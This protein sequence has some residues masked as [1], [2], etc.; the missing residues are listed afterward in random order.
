MAQSRETK[1]GEQ[2]SNLVE[3]HFFNPAQV[4]YYISQQ[5]TYTVDRIMELIAWVIEKQ[6]RRY[7]RDAGNTP[8]SEG[9]WLAAEL[10]KV[11]DNYKAKYKFEH[12]KLP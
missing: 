8:V 12:I 2:I 10:D 9:L 11:V 6:A 4:G 5:P 7:E 3:D 1:L